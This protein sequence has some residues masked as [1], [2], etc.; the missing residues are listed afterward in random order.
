MP[1]VLLDSNEP[2]GM[3]T[4]P[5]NKTQVGKSWNGVF[6]PGVYSVKNVD[7]KE[8][9]FSVDAFQKL[10]LQTRPCQPSI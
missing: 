8:D 5:I 2:T 6:S 3:F 1:K 9:P 7:P 4:A 10:L